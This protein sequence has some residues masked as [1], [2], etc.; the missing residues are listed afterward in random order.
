MK[1]LLLMLCIISIMSSCSIKKMAFNSISDMMAPHPEKKKNIVSETDPSLVIAGEDDITLAA[2]FFPTLLKTYELLQLQNPKH[3]GLTMM[4]G[5]L[6]IMYANAFIQT[7]AEFLPD[8]QYEKQNAEYLRAKKFYLR[9]AKY[10]LKSLELQYPGFSENI[11]SSDEQKI[12]NALQQC[13]KFDVES[14]YWAGAGL[15][16]AF[17]LEPLDPAITESVLGAVAMLEKATELDPQYN[18]GAVWDL[19][20]KFYAAA[21]EPLGGGMEK[22]KTAYEK[23]L[24]FSEGKSAS[25]YVTYARSLCI[26][27]QDTKGFDKALEQALAIDPN[28]DPHNRFITILA[29][30]QAQW[31]KEHKED[32]FIE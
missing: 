14:L 17:S 10:V 16:G 3:R 30:Q 20:T 22:A 25:A 32:F 15:L 12:A 28:A 26:P 8:N 24:Q 1:K 7:P 11:L 2:E 6:F 21:P 4:T 27:Q 23:L 19:L 18:Q 13:K 5:S 29:Q 31:L 9:G